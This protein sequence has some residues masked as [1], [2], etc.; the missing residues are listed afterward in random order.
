MCLVGYC[1]ILSMWACVIKENKHKA[2]PRSTA[3]GEL[4]VKVRRQSLLVNLTLSAC[5]LPLRPC[6]TL[7]PRP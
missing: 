5:C 1:C 6:G 3:R 2:Q 4:V 7:R